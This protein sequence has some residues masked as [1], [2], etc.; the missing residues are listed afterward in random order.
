MG[1]KLGS[2]L[3]QYGAEIGIEYLEGKKVSV[4]AYPTIYQM[5]AT[6]RGRTGQPLQDSE[7][8]VTSHLVGLFNRTAKMLSKGIRPIFVFDGPP[9]TLKKQEI[10]KR[11][12]RR[13]KAETKY[14]EALKAGKVE[15]AKKFA[16]QSISVGDIIEKSSKKLLELMGIPVVEAPHDA[17]AQASYLTTQSKCFAV[18]SPDYDAFLFK[19]PKVIRNLKMSDVNPHLFELEK[20]L[21]HLK[22]SYSQLIDV[23]LLLGTDFNQTEDTKG[24]KGIGPKTAL[25]LIK[26][27]GDIETLLS[28]KE[29]YQWHP[30]YPP[31]HKIKEYF[32]F[33]P[34]KQQVKVQFKDLSENDLY[35]F[36]VEKHDFSKNRVRKRIQEIKERRQKEEKRGIQSSLEK[37]TN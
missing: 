2:L 24:I 22:I 1:V 8:R 12:R 26:K 17:E 6:I 23:A 35:A 37:F 18:A 11:E 4:D 27:F 28:K 21:D 3:R 16:Q 7:G 19:S 33:P 13:K 20:V 29:E 14:Q 5:L 25:R 31:I 10:K 34:I 32:Q 9:H 30:S 15:K 36:L